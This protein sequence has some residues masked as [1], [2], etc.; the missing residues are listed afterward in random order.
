[1]LLKYCFRKVFVNNG[2]S[3]S[4]AQL[5]LL[6]QINEGGLYWSIYGELHKTLVKTGHGNTITKVQHCKMAICVRN[7]TVCSHWINR[8]CSSGFNVMFISAH[9]LITNPLISRSFQEEI[10]RPEE[11][12]SHGSSSIPWVFLRV[13]INNRHLMTIKIFQYSGTK[14]FCGEHFSFN[15]GALTEDPLSAILVQASVFT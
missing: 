3:L 2:R 10:L 9:V 12:R 1:M 14:D 15:L 4:C 5:K 13:I 8:D 11:K 6:L 7:N